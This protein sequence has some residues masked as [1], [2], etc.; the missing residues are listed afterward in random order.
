MKLL[1]PFSGYRLSSGHS[2][3][4]VALFVCSYF[5]GIQGGK[6]EESQSEQD[7]IF[8]FYLI[9]YGNLAL[10]IIAIIE[11]ILLRPSKI[12]YDK[13]ARENLHRNAGRE[14]YVSTS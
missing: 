2:F 6:D 13:D 12:N 10:I 1:D 11:T 8:C 4:H 7:V 5:V 14:V 9:R 3:F